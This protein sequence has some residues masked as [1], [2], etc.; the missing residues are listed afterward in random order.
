[1]PGLGLVVDARRSVKLGSLTVRTPTPGFTAQ[2]QAGS[3]PHGPFAADSATQTVSSTT[4][5]RLN[6]ATARYYV[7]WI[8]QLPPGG[9][10]AISEVTSG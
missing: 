2:I 7:V 1:M 8:A 4:T 5:F 6:G 3:S 9:K 10:A